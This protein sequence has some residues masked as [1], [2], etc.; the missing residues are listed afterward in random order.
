MKVKSQAVR[1]F[2]I[3][4]QETL[5]SPLL[6]L[7]LI[8]FLRCRYWLPLN[9]HSLVY[10][11]SQLSKPDIGC[12]QKSV[13]QKLYLIHF[14][15]RKGHKDVFDM[16]TLTALWLARSN[17]DFLNFPPNIPSFWPELLAF[18][19]YHSNIVGIDSG[20]TRRRNKDIIILSHISPVV[21]S[22]DLNQVI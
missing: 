16:W 15:C 9:L 11:W 2:N 20:D 21:K 8:Y 3:N 17:L 10:D 1:L 12:P 6:R 19:L 14:R 5:L 13:K 4:P 7:F 22:G 18:I